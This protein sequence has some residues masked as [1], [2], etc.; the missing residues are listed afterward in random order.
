MKQLIISEND[1]RNLIGL[2]YE[3]KGS[4]VAF[5][6]PNKDFLTITEEE[7]QQHNGLQ[8][9]ITALSMLEKLQTQIN[10]SKGD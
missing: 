9:V 7:K 3:I 8:N 6:F 2:L 10:K 4:L 1:Y 5:Y